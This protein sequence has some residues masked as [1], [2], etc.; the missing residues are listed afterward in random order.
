MENP[1]YD[2]VGGGGFPAEIGPTTLKKSL[3]F[4]SALTFVLSERGRGLRPRAATRVGH[5][6]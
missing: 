4:H 5:F 2:G 1:L 6:S 3:Q